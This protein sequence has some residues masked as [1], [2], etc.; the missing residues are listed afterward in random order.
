MQSF[1]PTFLRASYRRHFPRIKPPL[2]GNPYG[3]QLTGADSIP[4]GDFVEVEAD[5]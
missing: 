2:T 3:R 5:R 1:F 4:K